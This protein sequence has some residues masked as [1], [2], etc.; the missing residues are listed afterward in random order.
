MTISSDFLL[1]SRACAVL[2]GLVRAG[3]LVADGHLAL[4]FGGARAFLPRL[5]RAHHP[6]FRVE[7]VGSLRDSVEVEIGGEL[8]AGAARP[9]HRGD[10]VLDLLAQ[11]PLIG[12]L[13]FVGIAAAAGL[14][15]GR[16]VGEQPSGFVD[17][18]DV[19]GLEPVD[20]GSHEVADGAHLLAFER[21]AHLEHDRCGRLDLLAREQRTLGQHQMDAG[22]LH[23]VE[24]PDG[25]GEFALQRAQMVDVLNEARRAERVGLVEDLV[26]DAA[27][28][29]Q[30]AFGEFHAQPG[31]PVPRHHDDGAVV[32]HLVGNH[33]PIELLDDRGGS[34]RPRGR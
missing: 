8:H 32:P 27:A 7:A 30:P 21:A 23:P 6:A 2:R 34:P 25:A 12:D 1:C 26:A 33:L 3:Q 14:V 9:D 31:D 15:A 16:T 5:G 20:R 22:G 17:D 11:A 28:L 10:D 29:R 4:V 13:A 24:C 18:R 19:L